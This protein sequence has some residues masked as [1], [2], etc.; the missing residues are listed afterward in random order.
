MKAYPTLLS[1]LL[2]CVI[3]LPQYSINYKVEAASE[4]FSGHSMSKLRVVSNRLRR[5]SPPP[6]PKPNPPLHFSPPPPQ[7]PP[8]E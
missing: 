4:G 2:I 5:R 6:P 3:L 1:V 7:S 8:P